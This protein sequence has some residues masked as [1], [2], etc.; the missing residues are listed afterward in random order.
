VAILEKYAWSTHTILEGN[1]P[2]T[3]DSNFV[4]FHP[5]PLKKIAEDFQFS[6]NQMTWKPS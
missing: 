5:V 2:S 4:S 6:T 1:H 3:F